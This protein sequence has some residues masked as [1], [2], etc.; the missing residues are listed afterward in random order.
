MDFLHI[1][2]TASFYH[3]K[4]TGNKEEYDTVP[5]LTA[6]K[7]QLIPASSEILATFPGVPS[8]SLH[9]I[10][11]YEHTADI[12]NGDKLIT[13]D[14]KEYIVRGEAKKVV[15]DI[16]KYQELVGEMVVGV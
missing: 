11:T 13:T 2:H 14:S 12:R 9:E 3:F 4:T 7:I 6:I 8:Y 5:Y 15:T 1:T 16:L 10:F